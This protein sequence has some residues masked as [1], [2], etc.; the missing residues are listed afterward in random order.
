MCLRKLCARSRVHQGPLSELF[1]G[2]AS[3][4]SPAS[5]VQGIHC[6]Q[7][8]LVQVSRGVSAGTYTK[9]FAALRTFSQE[10][11]KELQ[12]AANYFRWMS[13]TERLADLL[14]SR[15]AAGQPLPARLRACWTVSTYVVLRRQVLAVSRSVPPA[16][17]SVHPGWPHEADQHTGFRPLLPHLLGSL[18][19][20][21]VHPVQAEQA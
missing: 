6:N 2:A 12:Q 10:Q 4:L 15:G 21:A 19:H 8:L 18:R 1:E 3:F 17:P 13:G 14:K 16:C 5:S 7:V 9:A 11:L 20:C